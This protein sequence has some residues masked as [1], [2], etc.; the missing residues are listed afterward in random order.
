MLALG[1]SSFVSALHV[2]VAD[3][4]ASLFSVEPLQL[5]AFVL[6]L[7]VLVQHEWQELHA[8]LL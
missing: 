6:E 3:F 2:V 7:L 1:L 8:S 4:D 5:Q